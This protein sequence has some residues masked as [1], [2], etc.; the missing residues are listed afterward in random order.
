MENRGIESLRIESKQFLINEIKRDRSAGSYIFY[1]RQ[2]SNHLAVAKDFISQMLKDKGYG[3]DL[4]G[5]PDLHFLSPEN[6]KIKLKSIRAEM[7]HTSMTANKGRSFFI[8]EELSAMGE[9]GMNSVL[10]TLEESKNS[11]FIFLTSSMEISK[12]ILSRSFFVDITPNLNYEEELYFCRGNTGDINDFKALGIKVEDLE[13]V[14]IAKAMKG[15]IVERTSMSRA[16]FLIALEEFYLNL[17]NFSKIDK[18]KLADIMMANFKEDKKILE[19][20]LY[21]F[22]LRHPQT[23]RI[24]KL[25]K[26]K[27]NLKYN[28]GVELVLYNFFLAV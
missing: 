7:S 2:G 28:V 25:L 17:E 11:I 5:N 22:T 18:L 20:I 19:T 4:V 10:K 26:V 15:F 14:D 13:I 8:I 1:G 16:V 9:D 12:T 21:D 23:N 24:E 3:D 6:G 27:G